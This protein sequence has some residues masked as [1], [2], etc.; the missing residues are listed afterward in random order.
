M[1]FAYRPPSNDNKAIFFNE[2]TTSLSQITNSYDYFVIK[3]DLSEA[4]PSIMA[5]SWP[6]GSQIAV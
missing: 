3:G 5:R 1:T 6:W 2:L 4:V